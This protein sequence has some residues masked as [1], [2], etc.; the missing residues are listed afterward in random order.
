MCAKAYDPEGKYVN[1]P[2]AWPLA[3]KP[4]DLEG[5]PPHVISVSELDPLRDE[6]LAYCEKLKDAGVQAESR[7][8]EGMP[9]AGD[10]MCRQV[11]GA[12]HIY[13]ETLESIKSFADS[14]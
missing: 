3:A 4:A 11:P 5:L 2:C 9:H 13:E 12:E 8:V 6:G 14:L 7:M 1:E 10:L